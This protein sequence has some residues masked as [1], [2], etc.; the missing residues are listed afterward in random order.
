METRLVLCYLQYL[1]IVQVPTF[2]LIF[3]FEHLGISE[4]FNRRRYL[5]LSIVPLLTVLAVWSNPR[6]RLFY[7]SANMV[8]TAT[9]DI[10]SIEY[11]PLFVLWSIYAYLLMLAGLIMVIMALKTTT[12]FYRNQYIAILIGLLVPWVF[13][14]LH[15]SG[16]FSL[17]DFDATTLAYTVTVICFIW[18]FYRNHL[19]DL[20]PIARGQAF[21]NMSDGIVVLDAKE[22]ITDFNPA[23]RGILEV[24]SLD[25]IGEHFSELFEVEV[26]GRLLDMKSKIPLHLK[27]GEDDFY[28]DVRI[29]PIR[30]KKGDSAGKILS[31][32]DVTRQK[33]LEYKL[34]YYATTDSLTGLYN[35]REFSRLAELELHRGIRYNNPLSIVMID[36]DHFKKV[37]DNFGHD[38]GDIAMKEMVRICRRGLREVDIFA[39]WGGEEFVVLLPETALS[40]ATEAAERL[41]ES[42]EKSVIEAPSGSLS[43]TVSVG[44]SELGHSAGT[45]EE[46]LKLAD[47]AMY[48]SKAMGRNRC[49]CI[50]RQ[51][52]FSTCPPTGVKGSGDSE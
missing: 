45:L 5:W 31:F 4:R 34:E 11:G 8:Q 6:H 27:K 3:V 42:I 9:I 16:T 35:R 21:M 17:K 36:I 7:K 19:F 51:G 22:R 28:Y 46:G 44:V 10:L 1:F 25:I 47:K 30:T 26:A 38:T 50:D 29:S 52:K 40:E 48:H 33:Q 15:I 37:N 12:A 49:S 24:L 43:I 18:A 32:R 14:I 13:N 20:Q 41:R 23:A 2:F 39:R